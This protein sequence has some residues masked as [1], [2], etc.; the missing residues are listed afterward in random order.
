[1]DPTP[2]TTL[3]DPMPESAKPAEQDDDDQRRLFRDALERKKAAGRDV[4][5]RGSR[6]Q[7]IGEAHNDHTRRQFRRKSGS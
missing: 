3:E 6:N 2:I 1:V 5:V 4:P 7:G